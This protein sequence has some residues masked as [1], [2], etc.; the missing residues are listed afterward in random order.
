MMYLATV[1]LNL[2]I[3]QAHLFVIREPQN[4]S[5][6][7][8]EHTDK[9]SKRNGNFHDNL[10][11]LMVYLATVSPESIDLASPNDGGINTIR[12]CSGQLVL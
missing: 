1:P 7:E 3:S 6:P 10:P 5:R 12:A 4:D 11:E 2:P 8:H 9:R